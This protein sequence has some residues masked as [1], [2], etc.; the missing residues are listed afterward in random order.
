MCV[1][2]CLSVLTRAHSVVVVLELLCTEFQVHWFTLFS[3]IPSHSPFL[4]FLFPLLIYGVRL[5]IGLGLKW[6]A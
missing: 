1:C 5:A 2:E 6:K 4:I 3:V